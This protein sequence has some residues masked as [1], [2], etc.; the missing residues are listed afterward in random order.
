MEG[1][2]WVKEQKNRREDLE[3]FLPLS[4]V[5]EKDEDQWKDE[6]PSILLEG[7]KDLIPLSIFPLYVATL[8]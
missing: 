5:L 4:I 2:L 3:N 8:P 6:S 7:S 1:N